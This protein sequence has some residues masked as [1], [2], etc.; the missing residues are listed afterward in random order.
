MSK[1]GFLKICDRLHT[2]GLCAWMADQW[3]NYGDD[4]WPIPTIGVGSVNNQSLF[5]TIK[6]VWMTAQ[7]HRNKYLFN[8]LAVIG[9]KEGK[10]DQ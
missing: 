8:I 1:P 2:K 10:H 4:V 5:Q 6:P 9:Y 3:F 7:A